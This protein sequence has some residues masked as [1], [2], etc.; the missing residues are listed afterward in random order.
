[1][2][3]KRKHNNGKANPN[4]KVEDTSPRVPQNEKIRGELKI[5]RRELTD[6]Q[7]KF[8]EIAL[9]KDTK[10]MFVSG[11]AGTSKTFL[12]VLSAL[13]LL[14]TRRMSDIIYL[15]S[16]VE[17][18]DNKLGYLPGEVADKLSPYVQ[19]LI[20][21]LA[22]FLCKSDV[23]RLQ[24]EGRLDSIPIGFLRGLNWNAKVIIADE[25]Q[26]CSTKELTTL[27]TRV[28]EFSKV[29]VLGDPD[30]SDIG[31]KSGFS[32]MMR[33]F[34]DEESRKN[35]VFTFEFSED[36]IVRSGLVKFII[37]KLRDMSSKE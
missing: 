33:G 19:P 20:D 3:K 37:K 6:K 12:A 18:S 11:P 21:K 17:S 31:V 10:M 16:A 2:S 14:N 34:S 29:F 36:D 9:H 13:E 7:K 25:A 24:K 28:G 8:L 27:I 1:M 4:Q 22:E 32:K 23:D 35:G 30:Q 5:T 26:N 15:R